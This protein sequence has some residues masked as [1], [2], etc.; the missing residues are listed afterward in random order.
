[1]YLA[2]DLLPDN[3]FRTARKFLG[4]DFAPDWLNADMLASSGI[5]LN[6]QRAVFSPDFKGRRVIEQLGK[7]LQSRGLQELLRHGDRNSMKFSVESRVPFLTVPM[8]NLLLS[9]DESYLISATG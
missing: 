3:A 6:E 8:A 4:R 7:S 2:K 9:V 1:M 5:H